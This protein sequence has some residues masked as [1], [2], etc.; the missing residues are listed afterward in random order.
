MD[1]TSSTKLW[2]DCLD[3]FDCLQP[4]NSPFRNTASSHSK[5]MG[6]HTSSTDDRDDFREPNIS[7]IHDGTPRKMLW[8]DFTTKYDGSR[9]FELS[10]SFR[11]RIIEMSR[12]CSHYLW[13][14]GGEG[15]TPGLI[16]IACKFTESSFQ[17]YDIRF[18]KFAV[19][20]NP[21]SVIAIQRFLG[22]LRKESKVIAG[23]VDIIDGSR[24]DD[25]PRKDTVPASNSLIRANIQIDSLTVC[26]NKEHQHR[27]LLE[28]TLSSCS[29]IMHS[30]E[31]GITME[32]EIGNLSVFDRDNYEM[33]RLNQE[34]I[35]KKN[36]NV[37][38]VLNGNGVENSRKFLQVHYRTFTKKATSDSKA[39]V[40]EWIKSNLASPDDIDDF[41]S[42]TIAATRF[43]FLKERT[44][45]LLDYLSNGLP[46]KGMGATSRAAKGFISR[47]IQTRSFLQLRVNPSQIYV[48]QHEM[49]EQG[50]GLKLGKFS[51]LRRYF[52]IPRNDSN[53]DFVF[54]GDVNI[55]SWFEKA[56]ST[57][58][59]SIDSEWWRV[60]SLKVTGF[61][62]GLV[63]IGSNFDSLSSATSPIDLDILLRKPTIKGRILSI[64]GIMSSLDTVLKY[65]D[66]ALLRAV[67]RD[68]IGRH[69]NTDKWDNVEK[70]YWLE[71]EDTDKRLGIQRSTKPDGGDI[72]KVAYSTNARFVRYGKG[73]KKG[74]KETNPS[75]R[76]RTDTDRLENDTTQT[77]DV[78]FDLAGVALRLRRNDLPEGVVEEDELATGFY[79]DIML[80]RVGYVEVLT[81]TNASGDISFNLSLFRVGLF[82]LGDTGRRIRQKYYHSLPSDAALS[83]ERK[84][85]ALLQ[86]CPFV[87]LAEGYLSSDNNDTVVLEESDLD[88]PE[89]VISVDICPASSTNGFLPLSGTALP[90]ETKVTVAK[91]VINYLSLNAIIRPFREIAD[92]FACAWPIRSEISPRSQSTNKTELNTTEKKKSPENEKL[93]Y[94]LK[95]LQL[96]VVAH[97][98]RV[99]FLADESDLNSRALVL[100]G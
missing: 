72:N 63:S 8:K 46:G 39:D 44:D 77:L 65:E 26:M 31:Q 9:N 30:S 96:K 37:L 19:Q 80:L 95:G 91:V 75:P 2:L 49:A 1:G 11:E 97:Y 69:I 94:S 88:G 4:I 53:L 79:Y 64:R 35:T 51:F 45:E 25:N 32:G 60:L 57:T 28:L 17:E 87:V 99:F 36:R 83:R 78:R 24:L 56:K 61:S 21:S 22:R 12:Q 43:T 81:T 58:K 90:P 3:L 34:S 73:G 13:G 33:N 18:R 7:D 86:P 100:K 54:E 82:D 59:D 41:L 89:F 68:N 55:Q 76:G 15:P 48:P 92:F 29:A 71:N 16:E 62:F 20:W 52:V 42:L 5:V 14:E 66:Y 23:Q 47:R 93:N 40:P 85:K 84:K 10:K 70:A 27:R 67:A 74:M 50:L 98:P 6:I 38:T